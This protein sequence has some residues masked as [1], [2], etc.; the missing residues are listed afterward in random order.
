MS[1]HI[2]KPFPSRNSPLLRFLPD[3]ARVGVILLVLAGLCLSLGAV[4][5]SPSPGSAPS[6]TVDLSPP[7]VDTLRL[8]TGSVGGTFLP[9]GRI[10]A[11]WWEQTVPDLVVLVD[12]T[13]G[14]VDNLH[15]LIKGRAD[16]AIVGGSPF[17]EILDGWGTNS[18]E[19]QTLC[20]VGTLYEDAEQYVIRSSLVRAGNLLDLSGVRMYPGPH[21]S[22]GEIDTRLILTTLGIEP[23]YIYVDERNKG[24]AAAAAALARGDFDAATFSGGV[25]IQAVT[26]LFRHYPGQFEI[27]PFTS[28]MLRRLIYHEKGFQRVVIRKGTYP[29]QNTNIPSVGGPNLLVASPRLRPR[30][31]ADL[32]QAVREGI[33][34]PGVGL[35]AATSHPVLQVLT[36]ELWDQVP[37]GH[38]CPC[39]V[40][41]DL[42]SAP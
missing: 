41:A 15:R 27:L 19:A 34:I 5:A 13:A 20:T 29:G 23:Q 22:G 40:T 3:T 39:L 28:H 30:I 18:E 38:R 7:A 11:A 24:Y 32:D 21:N 26:D 12:T 36:P 16:I 37:A 33:Q 8:A 14:S 35:R 2:E 17:Q 42:Q 31:L 4:E 25:P 9:V 1:A 10:L 6:G